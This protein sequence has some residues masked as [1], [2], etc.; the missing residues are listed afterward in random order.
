MLG[1]SGCQLATEG[2]R[3][4]PD[5]KCAGGWNERAK[6]FGEF[7]RMRNCRRNALEPRTH[8]SVHYKVYITQSVYTVGIHTELSEGSQDTERLQRQIRR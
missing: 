2:D 3:G 5:Y 8:P 1:E 6:L 4:L 7:A